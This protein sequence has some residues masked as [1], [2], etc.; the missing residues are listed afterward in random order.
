MSDERQ[1]NVISAELEIVGRET[2]YY[3][4]WFVEKFSLFIRLNWVTDEIYYAINEKL[5]YITGIFFYLNAT[6]NPIIYNV[7]SAKYRKA[8]LATFIHP[9]TRR[10]PDIGTCRGPWG[11][12]CRDPG[13]RAPCPDPLSEWTMTLNCRSWEA[14]KYQI[15]SSSIGMGVHLLLNIKQKTK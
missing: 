2:C 4:K 7:M 5:F 3:F 14:S 6:I 15:N 11:P 13:S 12:W 1:V 9:Y 8:F 10:C